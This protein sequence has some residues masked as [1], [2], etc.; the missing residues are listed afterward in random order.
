[1]ALTTDDGVELSAP[2]PPPSIVLGRERCHYLPPARLDSLCQHIVAVGDNL[3]PG[4]E[5]AEEL[6]GPVSLPLD[7]WV[8]L[9]HHCV[10]VHSLGRREEV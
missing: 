1:M 2:P 3:V 10:A 5:E 9:H 4:L 8:V 6:H 7:H